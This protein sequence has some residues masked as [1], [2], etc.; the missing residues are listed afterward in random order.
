MKLLKVNLIVLGAILIIIVGISTF[1]RSAT[2][3]AHENI[4]KS[5][6]SA[7]VVKPSKEMICQNSISASKDDVLYE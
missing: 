3:N 7:Q 2:R 1:V 4:R 6:E 5:V